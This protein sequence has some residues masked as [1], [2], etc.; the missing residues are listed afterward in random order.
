VTEDGSTFLDQF[1]QVLT[2][3]GN[4]L[5]YVRMVRSGGLHHC[6]ASIAFVPDLESVPPFAAAAEQLNL[7]NDTKQAAKTLDAV[8]DDMSKNFAE[9]T[10]YFQVL[11]SVFTQSL[12]S[13]D[14]KHLKNFYAI[15]P[16]LTISFVEK[17]LTLKERLGKKSGKVEAGFTDD[18]FA[19]GLAYILRVLDQDDDFDSLHWFDSVRQH[20]A[21][22]RA[23]ISEQKQRLAASSSSSSKN[24]SAQKDDDLQH[25]QI[26]AKR[27]AALQL[28]FELLFF[29]FTGARIFFRDTATEEAKSGEGEGSEGNATETTT[30]AP[31]DAAASSGSGVEGVPAAPPASPM[32]V[33]PPA[34]ALDFIPPPAPPL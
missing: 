12:R 29:S 31:A 21:Q 22:K 3:V 17:M 7:S 28:E 24:Q 8:L 10:D 13:E 4:A 9:G 34:P 33:P 16:P 27:I 18:G 14:Q 20:F 15:I 1:R 30:A 23:E 32:S 25:F 11:V 6:S 5:G 26:T 2:E 19:L